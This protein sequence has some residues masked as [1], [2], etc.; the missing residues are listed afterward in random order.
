MRIHPSSWL[1]LALGLVRAAGPLWGDIAL[2][3]EGQ[4][5]AVIVLFSDSPACAEA[6]Q[7]LQRYLEKMSGAK[8]PIA[9]ALAPKGKAKLLIGL[10]SDLP[11]D[12]VQREARGQL[13]PEGF[14]IL[15]EG[16][17][18]E[19]PQVV[20][21]GQDEAGLWFGVYEF[22][23]SLGCRWY[24]PGEWG[25]NVPRRP[26]VTVPPRNEV[27]NPDFIL[28]NVWWAYGGR[29]EWQREA[30]ALWRR[31]NKMGG[32]QA[33][34]GHN[35]HRILRPSQFRENPDLF[36]LRQ[37]TRYI[38][39]S[40][41]EQGWQPCTSNPQVIEIAARKAIAYFDENPEAYSFSLSPADGYGWCECERC[42]AQDPPEFRG[43]AK[44]GKGRRMSIFANAVAKRLAR[45]HPDKY[46]CWYAY[47]G[48]VEAP[49]DVPVH[50]NVVI[51]LAHYG[52]CGCNIH[53]LQDPRCELNARFVEILDAWSAKASKLF[54]REYWTT[55]VGPTDGLARICAA[56]SL[57]EDIPFFKARGVIGFSSESIPD[58]GA[59]ALNFWLAARKMWD[60][61]TDTE[62]LLRDF[63]AGMYGPAAS[64]MRRYFETILQL[65]RER[66]HRGPFFPPFTGGKREGE[67]LE[68]LGALLDEA[69]Q[70]CQT[71]RQRARVKL[72]RDFYEYVMRMRRYVV[73]P[74]AAE[75]EAINALINGMEQGHSL[76][77]DFVRHRATFGR[78]WRVPTKPAEEYCG[79]RVKPYTS[80]PMPEGAEKVA[81]AV[82]GQHGFVVL[83]RAGEELRGR[84]EVRRLGRY[85][86]PCAFVVLGPD[87]E[88]LLEGEA[89]L[90]QPAEVQVTAKKAGLHV[91]AVNTGR[92][93]ARVLVHNQHFCLV[94]RR[95]GLLGAQPRA[96]FFVL[97]LAEEAHLTLT[98]E[99]TGDPD[100][101][102]ETA[103]MAVYD[104]EGREIARGDT[105]SGRPFEVRVKVPPPQR[106]KAWSLVLAKAEKGV[107][108]DLRLELGPGCSE[109]I[110]THPTRLLVPGE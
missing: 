67:K 92:N 11:D 100:S 24:F 65:C 5:A 104:P 28:R 55:L 62:Q 58:Y 44:R 72:T 63:Y 83:L 103:L 96:Y 23:E 109:F 22:L 64:V 50:P 84:V 70:L 34:M 98:S 95:L 71:E 2:V 7:E 21:A 14:W 76:A 35:L 82:R 20:I 33:S 12:L 59:C 68:K 42:T 86:S 54:I 4:P 90:E 97:P 37:G 40:D 1:G 51:S 89:S 36:P 106:G 80:E 43:L 3:Q 26:T 15:A 17:G 87:R 31:R 66:G 81:F 29:P 25:E 57:A 19:V 73:A 78:R 105:I 107:L 69:A 18:G 61:E 77:V 56:Y 52:W 41:G 88:K 38:P 74:T 47:A 79:A 30:Y 101:P 39:E 93:A 46:V 75:R 13:R 6:A 9:P 53:S 49:K 94:G 32:V 10:A 27:Q 108:E 85:L 102:G 110:A 8:L 48:T 16:P 99:A 45:R 91:I 60:A